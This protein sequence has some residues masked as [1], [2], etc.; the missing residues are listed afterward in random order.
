MNRKLT[1]VSGTVSVPIIRASDV[2]SVP[3]HSECVLKPYPC[4]ID[5]A[6]GYVDVHQVVDDSTL[7]VALM[8]V[9]HHLLACMQINR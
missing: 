9:D 2:I 7:N 5:G 1:D 8:L 3:L 6:R 4:Q